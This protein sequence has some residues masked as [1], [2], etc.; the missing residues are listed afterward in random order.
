[1][2]TLAVC[3]GLLAAFFITACGYENETNPKTKLQGT[4]KSND[5]SVYSGTLIITNDRITIDGYYADQTPPRGD[6]NNRP[7][8][9]FT[10]GTGLKWRS[11]VTDQKKDSM[12]GIIYITDRGKEQ[13][14]LPFSYYEGDK[15]D[16]GTY[17]LITDKFL[18]FTFGDRDEILENSENH[19]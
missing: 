15:W 4:W 13:D 19:H 8:K 1:M 7:F 16:Y 14:G 12:E 3:A 18:C 6:D 17:P 9:N 5:P 11:E 2:K 10:K